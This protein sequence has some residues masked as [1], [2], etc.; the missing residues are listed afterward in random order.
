MPL[1][2]C[3]RTVTGSD[4]MQPHS[5]N[6]AQSPATQTNVNVHLIKGYEGLIISKDSARLY[7]SLREGEEYYLRAMDTNTQ[8]IIQTYSAGRG[9]VI[10]GLSPDSTLAFAMDTTTANVFVINTIDHTVSEGTRIDT[11]PLTDMVVDSNGKSTYLCADEYLIELDTASQT[12]T[13]SLRF[14]NPEFSFYP[15]NLAINSSGS[16]VYVSCWN[17]GRQNS[18]EV[19]DT[20]RW[21]VIA[22][23]PVAGFH[24]NITVSPDDK[25]LYSVNISDREMI[26]IDAASNKIIQTLQHETATRSICCSPDG[27]QLFTVRINSEYVWVLDAK[28]LKE[29]QKIDTGKTPLRE[30]RMRPDNGDIYVLYGAWTQA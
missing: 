4:P 2:T 20:A 15:G 6:I 17:N 24:S 21:N 27:K 18:I 8:E 22:S 10:K 7:F 11:R 14:Y 23:I 13:R 28:T 25:F 12:V 26:M 29:T 9:P 16:R 30:V 1:Y 5:P 3:P 19:I